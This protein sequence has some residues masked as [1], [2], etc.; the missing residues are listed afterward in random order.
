MLMAWLLYA[1]VTRRLWLFLMLFSIS[2]FNKETTAFITVAYAACFYDRLSLPVFASIGLLQVGIF[3]A[4][5]GTLRAYFAMNSG[6]PMEHW[7]FNHIDWL[8]T[9]SFTD[10]AVFLVILALVLL[11]WPTN[12][13]V[14]RRSSVMILANVGLYFLGAFPGEWRAFYDSLPLLSMFVC[15]NLLLAGVWIVSGSSEWAI[16]ARGEPG[17]LP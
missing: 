10:F 2:C 8:M 15:R 11:K 6:V 7:W 17:D 9:R 1:L 3:A 13:L 12:P 4:V 5:Y 16:P 14:L